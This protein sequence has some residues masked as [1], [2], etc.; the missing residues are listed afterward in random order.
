MT[1][2]VKIGLGASLATI[3]VGIGVTLAHAPMSVARVNRASVSPEETIAQSQSSADYCQAQELLPSGTKA[4]RVSLQASIGPRV[5]LSVSSNGRTIASGVQGS[6]W[7]GAVVSV[8]VRPLAS[9]VSGVTVCV[10]FQAH[11]ELL[12]LYGKSVP[13]LP[14]ST[15]GEAKL[16]GSMRVEYLHVGTRSWASMLSSIARHI[17]LGRAFEGAAIA[18]LV[19]ALLAAIAILTS[20]LVARELR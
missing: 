9:T 11:N 5:A 10:S 19:F 14:A 18:Y 4:I 13:G 7:T 6:A 16:P 12:T 8:P 17:G 1:R 2:A 20:T 15:N 3:V